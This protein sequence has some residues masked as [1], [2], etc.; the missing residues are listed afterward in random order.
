MRQIV[1][2][3]NKKK[4]NKIDPKTDIDIFSVLQN[5]ISFPVGGYEE[6]MTLAE[7]VKNDL[8]LKELMLKFN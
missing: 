8:K 5:N 6:P 7:A 3:Y 1:N 2:V 4:S